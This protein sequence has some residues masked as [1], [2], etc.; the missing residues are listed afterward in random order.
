M[1]TADKEKAMARMEQR[2]APG[3]KTAAYAA[4]EEKRS[5]EKPGEAEQETAKRKRRK[6]G[7]KLCGKR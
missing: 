2:L 7:K 1:K 3:T 6:P 4:S 5:A